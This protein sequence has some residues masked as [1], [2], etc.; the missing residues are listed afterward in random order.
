MLREILHTLKQHQGDVLDV[1][2]N[3]GT[4]VGINIG[5][6]ERKLLSIIAHSP[7]A[8][9]REMADIL[10]VTSRQCERVLAT[11]KQKGLIARIGANKGGYWKIL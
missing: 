8:P 5:E 4:N 9:A 7:Q 3:V 6:N 11:M 10:G 2:T 1:G